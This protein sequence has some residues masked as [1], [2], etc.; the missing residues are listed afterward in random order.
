MNENIAKTAVSTDLEVTPE[1]N[2]FLEPATFYEI[3]A[4]HSNKCL[5][6]PESEIDQE[7]APVIQLSRNG[8]INQQW[9]IIPVEDGFCKI[10]ARTSGKSL[11]VFEAR[12]GEDVE[13][14]Q[15][16]DK[17]GDNQMWRIEHLTDGEHVI[18]AKHSGRALAVKDGSI[19]DQAV[20][21]QH[22]WEDAN[23]Q[24]WNFYKVQENQELSDLPVLMTRELLAKETT[25]LLTKESAVLE[26]MVLQ[27]ASG[28][29]AQEYL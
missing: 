17:G 29:D 14:I 10:I 21:V 3:V 12:T 20:I 23:H 26:Q 19:E 13:V 6:V 15:H 28:F 5:S 1:F 22:H 24:K 25:E 9:E 7:D 16:Q 2:T 8:G 11:D 27:E 4:K 18:V